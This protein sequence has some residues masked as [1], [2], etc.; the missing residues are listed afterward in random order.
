MYSDR[1]KR[2]F[3]LNTRLNYLSNSDL[4]KC[5]QASSMNIS[6]GLSQ[7]FDFF[8]LPVFVK[9]IPLTEREYKNAFSTQNLYQLPLWYNYGVGSAGL[10]AFRELLSHIKTTGWVLDQQYPFFPI[11]YHYRILKSQATWKQWDQVEL[12]KYIQ[13]WNQSKRIQTYIE[14]RMQA[15]YEIT[16]FLEYIPDSLHTWFE[17]RPLKNFKNLIQST[18]KGLAFMRQKGLLHLDAHLANILTDGKNA[19]ISDFGLSLDRDF[20]LSPR[21]HAFFDA[22]Q[23]YD[24]AE[25][26]SCLSFLLFQ[27]F[28]E[29][30]PTSQTKI[31]ADLGLTQES[32]RH[33]LILQLLENLPILQAQKKLKIQPDLFASL[34]KHKDTIRY[35]SQ[36]YFNLRN[37]P[38]PQTQFD[39]KAAAVQ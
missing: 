34:L 32:N 19:Y 17:N 26:L 25:F 18:Q 28:A 5:F 35:M 30:P 22:H 10:G 6:W 7:R 8:D 13:N 24:Q 36:F 16:L 31:L 2:Y 23:N 33:L 4:L 15:P 38:K 27:D 14:E 21:E 37:L 3:E 20:M 12:Q 29:L 11:L 39:A 1:I 9:R